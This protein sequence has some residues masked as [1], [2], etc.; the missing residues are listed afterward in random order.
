MNQTTDKSLACSDSNRAEI[1]ECVPVDTQPGK[2]FPAID[3][4]FEKV[5]ELY[6]RPWSGNPLMLR[7]PKQASAILKEALE[8]NPNSAL[9]KSIS[10]QLR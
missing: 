3:Y 6:R 4:A 7:I 10:R 8:H 2:A 9:L 1:A 5:L